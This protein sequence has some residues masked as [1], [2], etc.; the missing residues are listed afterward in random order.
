[1]QQIYPDLWRTEPEHPV[2]DKLPDLMMHAYLLAREQGNV[3]FC[4]AEHHADQER[5]ADQGGITRHYPTHWPEAAPG[6]A[7]IRQRFGSKLC[8]HRLT[9][10]AVREFGP[11]DHTFEARE[12]HVGDIGV[13]PS[14]GHTPGS[15]CFLYSSSATFAAAAGLSR[16]M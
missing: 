4:R 7:R 3:L 12:V 11:V 16:A 14:S 15:T 2:P 1:M 13:T 10:T 5:I 9:E 8:C 6:L